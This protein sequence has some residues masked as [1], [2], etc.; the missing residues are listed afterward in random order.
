[1][2]SS[3]FKSSGFLRISQVEQF[4][5]KLQPTDMDA[6]NE[7][8]KLAVDN[9]TKSYIGQVRSVIYGERNVGMTGTF[10]SNANVLATGLHL[11]NYATPAQNFTAGSTL[12]VQMLGSQR[13]LKAY[14]DLASD[15]SNLYRE[16]LELGK[17]LSASPLDGA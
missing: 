11:N 10:A 2:L 5:Q 9:R 16:G 6:F 7:A 1:M 12:N 3:L 15:F 14:T 4:G 8:H 17:N 13:G